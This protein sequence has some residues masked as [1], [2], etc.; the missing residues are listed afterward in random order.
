MY[1]RR[2]VTVESALAGRNVV[3]P[4]RRPLNTVAHCVQLATPEISDLPNSTST[5]CKPL[6]HLP[7]R[8]HR[9]N[10]TSNC[11]MMDGVRI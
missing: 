9:P 1:F 6:S 4:R 5:P 10:F 2:V 8:A 7:Q 11:S 3:L